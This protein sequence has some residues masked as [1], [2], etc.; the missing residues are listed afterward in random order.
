MIVDCFA[1]G[2]GASLGIERALGV[3]PDIAINH[4]RAA[5]AVHAANHPA[6][7]HMRTDVW[8][9]SPRKATGGR[10]VELAWFS[11]D[12]RH[13]SKA[14]GGAPVSD[15]VRSLAWVV[16][17][18]ARDVRPTVI[19]LEN[20][21]EFAT[22]GPLLSSGQPCTARRGW[23]FRRWWRE[24]ESLGY[25]LDAREL[26][27]CDYG[28]PTIRKRLF[29]IARRDGRPIVW[30]EPTHGPGRPQPWRVAADCID[31]SLPV[32]SIFDRGRP[33]A[34]A[35]Q[36][37]I[38]RGLERYVLR[39]PQPFIVPIQNWSREA[40]HSISE[41]LRTVT[42]HPKGGG[43]ALVAAWLA[44]HN[45]G[46]VGHD[47]RDPVSTITQSGSHQQ[48]CTAKVG[49]RQPM[50]RAW[51]AKYYGT[52]VGQSVADSLHSTTTKARFG[53]V[54]VLDDI[55]DIGMRMLAPRELFRAQGFDERYQIDPVVD[56]RPLPKTEQVRLCGNSV[57]PPLAEALVAANMASA[58]ARRIH[59]RRT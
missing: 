23:T 24:L 18:W 57:C 42:A 35:T 20:V 46:M 37:R 59:A 29:I 53:L 4:D 45:G 51:L 22:W 14:K 7:E 50:V 56:G 17:R 40:V 30:P 52:A 33:L 21:E 49:Q 27:A 12:C 58:D 15:Q 25:E 54:T 16:V 34:E 43:F 31:W 11:P 6:T 8:D 44:Q 48:L 28:A 2:G 41:P 55:A 26:R 13:F 3:S 47:L 38:A 39:H 10:P 9:V 1:G 36:R 5:L 32:P 19:M